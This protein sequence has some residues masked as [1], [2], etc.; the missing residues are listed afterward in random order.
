MW[1]QTEGKLI[2]FKSEILPYWTEL[3][4]KIAREPSVATQQLFMEL[5]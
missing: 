4:K 3:S 5:E 2:S 1:V